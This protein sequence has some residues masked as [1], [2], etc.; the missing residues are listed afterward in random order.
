MDLREAV[1]LSQL[2]FQVG[3]VSFLDVLD[4]QRTLYSAEIDL[5][6]SETKVSTDLITV[7]KTLGG[8]VEIISEKQ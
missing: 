1:R 4:A 5:A 6:R 3:T 7:Y 2:R 8:G